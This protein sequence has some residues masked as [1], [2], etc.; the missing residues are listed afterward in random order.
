MK[1]LSFVLLLALLA[2]S[3]AP[4]QQPGSLDG[5][6][7]ES[8]QDMSLL[9]QIGSDAI[10][11]SITS[12]E[13]LGPWI[14]SVENWMKSVELWTQKSSA[15]SEKAWE[16]SVKQEVITNGVSSNYDSLKTS[17]KYYENGMT[18][19][20]TELRRQYLELWFWRATTAAALFFL[21][22]K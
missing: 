19:L 13:K 11:S 1:R 5:T 3:L 10:T 14:Q 22:L 12:F 18:Q 9:W 20:T 16:L 4:A 17:L 2:L 7:Q 6:Q 21:L 15:L 8:G